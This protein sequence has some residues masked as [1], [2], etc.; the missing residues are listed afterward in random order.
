MDNEII[1]RTNFKSGD[2]GAII[3][4]HGNLY[5]KEYAYDYTFEA[6]VGEEMSKFAKR[7]NPREQ[8][9]IVEYK[10][11]IV[12]S[13]SICESSD[14]EAQLRW[15]LISPKLR[16]KGIGQNLISQALKFVQE[17]SY[18]Q[19]QLWTVKG[20]ESAKKLYLKEN[21]ILEKE[22]THNIWGSNQTEQKYT[23]KLQV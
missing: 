17:Q 2:L 4:L 12:G 1:I 6:Y 9:W 19:V 10:N 16:G 20:L 23:K 3:S 18:Q 8:I 5:S 14:I 21:F 22:I 11:E 7:K 13:I 15:F